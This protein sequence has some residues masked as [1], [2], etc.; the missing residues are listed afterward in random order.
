MQID[1]F[2]KKRFKVNLHTHTSASDGHVTPEEAIEIY[3]QQGYDG[4][5]LSDHWVCGKE[6][7]V[8][9][10]LILS[11]AEYN[12][13]GRD[14]V[15]GVF[16][17]VGFGMTSEPALEAGQSAQ[18]LIDGIHRAGGLA[19]LAHP[20]WSLNTPEQIMALRDVDMT[21]IYNTVS[22][23]HHSRR[24]DSSLIVD[25][26]ASQGR[27]YPLVADDDTHYYD[28][29]HCRS[30]IMVE[31]EEL[32][33]ESLKRAILEKKFYATQGP[34]LRVYRD[35]GAIVA[36]CSPCS[37]IVFHSNLVWMPRVFEGEGITEARYT[38][39]EDERYVRVAVMDGEGRYAWSNIVEL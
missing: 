30:W 37:E 23:V 38:P 18:E 28:S 24:P 15:P 22:G 31:A 21:E 26:I 25:M 36:E 6:R 34:E 29:D 11:G 12:T 1:M 33:A 32:T 3:R 5:V 2:G 17:I 4:L 20:A 13:P 9:E 7:R 8:G 16:H 39:A 19:I 14:G 10:M 35:G 27:Y